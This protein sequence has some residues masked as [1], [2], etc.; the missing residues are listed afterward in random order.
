MTV[1]MF[2]KVFG[3]TMAVAL[4]GTALVACSNNNNNASSSS[5]PSAS[6]SASASA[7]ATSSGEPKEFRFSLTEPP[8]LDPSLLKDAQSIIVG[9]GLF[10]GLTRLD[11]AGEPQPAAATNWDISEDGKTYTFH[12]RDGLKWS[13]GDPVLASDFEFAWKR[14]LAPE[15]ASDYAY[16]LYY[17]QGG[18]EYNA[19]EGS[20]DDVGVKALD[21]KT[22]EVKLANPTPYFVS[23]TAH[24]SYWPENQKVV[25][26]DEAWATEASTIVTN[27]AFT[28]KEWEHNDHLTLVK[29]PD[30]WDAANIHFDTVSIA[31]LTDDANTQYNA[32]QAGD[33]DWLGAQAGSVP[34]DHTA[35]DIASGAAQVQPVAS[36][37]YY[38][39]NTTKAPFNNAKIR[40]AFS[41]A[42]DRQS[43]IDNITKANQTPAYALVPP[44]IAGDGGKKFRE[45]YP[46]TS[47]GSTNVEEAKKLLQEGLDELGMSELPPVTLLYNT[48]EGHQKIA[49]AAA[50]MWRTA[51]GVE[52]D[53]QN[54]EWGTF[55]ETR[56]AQQ[57]DIA[58]AGWGADFNDP[59]N[60]T[61]DLIYSK[62]GN[63]NGK[64][65][66]TE[67]DKLLDESLM[68][69]DNAKRMELIAQAEKIAMADDTAVLPFYYYTTVTEIKPGITG[70]ESD[71]GGH[72]HWV[73]GDIQQ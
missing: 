54:Q 21:E 25:E 14:T 19:G 31:P 28:L 10:E 30:Y 6:S 57:F 32:F 72:L 62:S 5:S 17:I 59:I 64:Y 52:V 24:N 61:Y 46:D 44:S 56:S 71:Y 63:N 35:Q 66:N 37:Y 45:L 39:F 27:G 12:L 69:T 4:V 18:T 29:N 49:E 11:A 42:I 60:F 58:R 3:T 13:N 1:N 48:D 7:S 50:D 16:F 26:A 47:F 53:V 36:T 23:L 51:L 9:Q 15:T 65:S 43:I 8:S 68:T 41:L 70:V 55:L 34:T 40:K 2:K 33:I 22:L 67:V 73:Y 38:E 20:A